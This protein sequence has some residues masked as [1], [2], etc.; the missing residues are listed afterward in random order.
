MK[1]I[2]YSSIIVRRAFTPGNWVKTA[3]NKGN[4]GTIQYPLCYN[5]L[6]SHD[7]YP[8][9]L[10]L[11]STI[12]QGM[13][14]LKNKWVVVTNKPKANLTF[15]KKSRLGLS[16]TTH[17]YQTECAGMMYWHPVFLVVQS[18]ANGKCHR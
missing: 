4:M 15:V 7:N 5:S 12:L 18:L 6:I 9:S 1:I 17:L 8:T 10:G 11:R 3:E 16:K 2:V 13:L 14:Q